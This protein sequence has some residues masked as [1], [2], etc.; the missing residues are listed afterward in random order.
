MVLGQVLMQAAYYAIVMGLSIGIMAMLMRGFFWKYLKVKTSF[1]KYVIIKIR[2]HL[3][4]YFAVGWEEE[5]FLIYK[6]KKIEKRIKLESGADY[7]YRTLGVYWVDIDEKKGA[8]CKVDYEAVTGHD[9]EMQSNLLARAL[10]R[11]S[12][13]DNRE[14]LMMLILIGIGIALIVVGFLAFSSYNLNREILM[15]LPA[16]A[17]SIAATA[18]GGSSLI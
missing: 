9:Q 12:V 13:T 14:K 8:I 15:Q 2:T 7:F 4:D 18:G 3:R 11:P 6:S 5:G 1:G 10:T 16:L 17:K